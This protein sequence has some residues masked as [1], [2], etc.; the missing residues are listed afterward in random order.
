MSVKYTAYEIKY[1]F[2]VNFHFP[3]RSLYISIPEQIDTVEAFAFAKFSV[4]KPL[5]INNELFA[6]P[7]S[8]TSNYHVP[9]NIVVIREHAFEGCNL[10]KVELTASHW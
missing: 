1:I 9:A 10:S 5:I 2:I 3:I 6:F 7:R 8:I 4:P